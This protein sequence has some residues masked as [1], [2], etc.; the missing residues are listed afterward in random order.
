MFSGVV[1]VVGVGVGVAGGAYVCT[2][3][4]ARGWEGANRYLLD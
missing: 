1:G 2:R 4:R 3:A